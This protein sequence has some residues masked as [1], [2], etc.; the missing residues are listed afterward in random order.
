MEAILCALA[1]D[2]NPQQKSESIED[3]T[4]RV[5]TAIPIIIGD[6][7][8]VRDLL[9]HD[10]QK[11]TIKNLNRGPDAKKEPLATREEIKE[12]E[13]ETRKV[14]DLYASLVKSLDRLADIKSDCAFRQA[15]RANARQLHCHHCKGQQGPCSCFKVNRCVRK[16]TAKCIP[17]HCAHC[18]GKEGMRCR[19]TSGCPRIEGKCKD[20]EEFD[21]EKRA[22]IKPRTIKGKPVDEEER[23]RKKG[24]VDE[25]EDKE[26]EEEE[27]IDDEEEEGKDEEDATSV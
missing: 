12:Y 23:E 3:R 27:K 18:K 2:S 1:R 9:V 25:E 22:N 11:Q 5:L 4:R 14:Q 13:A 6:H 8:R 19:C 10:N 20:A 21:E 26:E 16:S 15:T 17:A 24:K 7:S